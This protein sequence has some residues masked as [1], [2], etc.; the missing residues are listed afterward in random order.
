VLH[1]ARPAPVPLLLRNSSA[2]F[3]IPA[4][5]F[6]ATLSDTAVREAYFMGQRHD[7]TMARFLDSYDKHLARPKSGPYVSSVAFL[8]HIH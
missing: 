8:T 5:G 7:E 4:A 2:G 3:S 1:G 6:D